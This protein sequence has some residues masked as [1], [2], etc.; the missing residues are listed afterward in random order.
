MTRSQTAFFSPFEYRRFILSRQNRTGFTSV[1]NKFL[2]RL[3]GFVQDSPNPANT[4]QLPESPTAQGTG[5][6]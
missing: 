1:A 2:A 5:I 6:A 3:S 4:N